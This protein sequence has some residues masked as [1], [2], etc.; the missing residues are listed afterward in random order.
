MHSLTLMIW[1]KWEGGQ[2]KSW[3]LRTRWTDLS[4]NLSS[5]CPRLCGHQRK[6]YRGWTARVQPQ[7]LIITLDYHPLCLPPLTLQRHITSVN[8]YLILHSRCTR[9]PIPPHIEADW[10]IKLWILYKDSQLRTELRWDSRSRDARHRYLCKRM[11][12]TSSCARLVVD[13]RL[14]DTRIIGRG[15]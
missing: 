14:T 12:F 6:T 5:R 10:V 8:N 7:R 4:A 9:S 13:F 3:A 11:C 1:G 15:S 2:K